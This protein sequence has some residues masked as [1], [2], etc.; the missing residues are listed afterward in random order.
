MQ[1]NT[2]KLAK[3]YAKTVHFTNQISTN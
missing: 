3:L 2:H 1:Y